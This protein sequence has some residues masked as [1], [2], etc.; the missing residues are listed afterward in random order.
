MLAVAKERPLK[1]RPERDSEPD[2]CDA[3][4]NKIFRVILIEVFIYRVQ[5]SLNKMHDAPIHRQTS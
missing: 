1:F 5:N 3:L 4:N 2:L